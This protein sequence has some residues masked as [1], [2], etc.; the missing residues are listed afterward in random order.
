MM[1]RPY[2]AASCEVVFEPREWH[3]TMQYH[4][5]PPAYPPSP[6]DMVRA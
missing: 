1:G 3:Y 4:C 5:R 2:P 6:R